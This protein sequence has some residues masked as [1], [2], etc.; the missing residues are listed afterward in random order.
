MLL[1]ILAGWFF[2]LSQIEWMICILLFGIVISLELMN[3]AIEATVDIAMPEIHPQ[4]KLA[5]DIAAG[6]VLLSAIMAIIIGCIIFIPKILMY[7]QA[8]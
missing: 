1:V 4:A 6:A 3:T 8:G 5:K 2:G 7:I